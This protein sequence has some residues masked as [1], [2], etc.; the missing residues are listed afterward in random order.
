MLTDAGFE[1]TIP[2]SLVLIEARKP[3][4]SAVY[5][6]K[7]IDE[8]VNWLGH[9]SQR[10]DRKKIENPYLTTRS[11]PSPTRRVYEPSLLPQLS[12]AIKRMDEL[13]NR[14]SHTSRRK[15]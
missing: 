1:A 9:T 7:R 13:V 4:P 2:G 8:L 14:L 3:A 12:P 5:L 6:F 15:D 11:R 10:E